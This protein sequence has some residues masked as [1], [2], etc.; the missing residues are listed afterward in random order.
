[1]PGPNCRGDTKGRVERY[2]CKPKFRAKH[3][4]MND[5]HVESLIYQVHHDYSVSYE[6]ARRLNFDDE[7][8]SVTIENNIA[9]FAMKEHF[10]TAEAA[11]EV[12][13]PFVRAWELSVGPGGH[14][15]HFKLLF[16]RAEIIDRKPPPEGSHVIQAE[17]GQIAKSGRYAG[18]FFDQETPREGDYCA[19]EYSRTAEQIELIT[20]LEMFPEADTDWLSENLRS[21]LRCR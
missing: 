16:E 4:F 15:Q 6:N 21:R 18:F 1:M 13:D 11:R 14:P 9:R 12:I 2:G 7:C 5:P 10:T 3:P 8:F 19:L 20:G 17:A